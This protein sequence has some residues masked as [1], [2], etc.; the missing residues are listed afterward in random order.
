MYAMDA[1]LH[2]C[3]CLFEKSRV[4]NPHV[5]QKQPAN[6]PAPGLDNSRV[7]QTAYKSFRSGMI[8][9]GKP[10]GHCRRLPWN[11]SAEARPGRDERRRTRR[12]REGGRKG[13][14]QPPARWLRPSRR[15]QAE[16]KLRPLRAARPLCGALSRH[17]IAALCALA[18]R[19]ARDAGGA[20]RGAPHDRLRLLA[21]ERQPDRQLFRRD[22]RG[23]GRA[24]AG[25][26][27]ALLPRH[28]AR[29][30]HRRRSAQRGVRP[31]H[32]ALGLPS[33]TRPRPAS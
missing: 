33:S 27:G 17:A 6:A 23:R 3:A 22:D 1:G 18:G 32:L 11:G 26:R 10:S 14:A 31:P 16:V 12:P 13:R 8:A 2:G 4:Y 28:H 25:E 9:S 24:R 29:R 7:S 5:Q 21:R 15:R 19:G 30:A 20:A